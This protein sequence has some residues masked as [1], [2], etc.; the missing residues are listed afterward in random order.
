MHVDHGTHNTSTADDGIRS[1]A[2]FARRSHD[3]THWEVTREAAERKQPGL[4][5][6]FLSSV[7][8]KGFDVIHLPATAHP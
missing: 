6:T 8:R 1:L 3:A 7:V 5:N 4:V 2:A